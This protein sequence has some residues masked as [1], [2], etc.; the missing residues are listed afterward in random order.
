MKKL[1]P[2]LLLPAGAAFGFTAEL[3]KYVFCRKG[4]KFFNHFLLG[5]IRIFQKILLTYLD[6]LGC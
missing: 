1:L 3:Y 2:A 4:S 5:Y 6:L